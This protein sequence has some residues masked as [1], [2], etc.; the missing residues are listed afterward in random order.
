M[1]Q[2]QFALLGSYDSLSFR[3]CIWDQVSPVSWGVRRPNWPF[4]IYSS[5]AVEPGWVFWSDLSKHISL[6]T[7]QLPGDLALVLHIGS[8]KTTHLQAS[9]FKDLCVSETTADDFSRLE[10]TCAVGK[11]RFRNCTG[12]FNRESTCPLQVTKL[13]VLTSEAVTPGEEAT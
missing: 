6:T 10:E 1:T 11:A 2:T 7:R 8:S 4:L 5:C 13:W 9:F 3:V 12:Q